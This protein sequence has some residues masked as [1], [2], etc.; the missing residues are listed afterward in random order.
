MIPPF[1]QG[2]IA[3][4]FTVFDENRRLDEAGQRNLLD[5]LVARGG[6]SAFFLRCGLGQMYTYSEDDVRLMIRLATD[7]LRGRAPVMLGCAGVWDRNRAHLPDPKVYTGQAVAFGQCALE[8]GADAAVFTLPE[9]IRPAAGE[10]PHDVVVRYFETLSHAIELPI[11]IYQAPQTDPDYMV[12]RQTMARLAQIPHVHGIKVSTSDA[13][14]LC[15]LGEVLEG[16]D[17]ALV[18]G[19]ET[20]YYAG[21]IAGARGVIGQGTTINPSVINAVAD[22]VGRGD[23]DAAVRAQRVVNLLV[24]EARNP[25]SYF[26]R[27]ANEQGYAMPNYQRNANNPYVKER[28]P[29]TDSDYEHY[30]ALHERA[31]DE[32]AAMSQAGGRRPD[33]DARW[34]Q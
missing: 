20:V 32:L 8:H 17:A 14:Y 25:V 24:R 29:L 31:L 33:V 1:I 9:C 22:A 12:T 21:L 27:Y 18:C 13:E 28:P 5:F 16:T 19:C 2:S 11:F 7:H 15:D 26:L 4:V 6:I 10:S 3:P 30:K 34:K 23:L